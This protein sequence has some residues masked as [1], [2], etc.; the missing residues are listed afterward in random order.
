MTGANV[1]D[2]YL[3]GNL[4]GFSVGL[5]ISLLLLVLTLRAARLPGTPVA[6]IVLAGCSILWNAGGLAY[7]IQNPRMSMDGPDSASIAI[8][9]QFTGAGVWP[10]RAGSPAV[11]KT[12]ATSPRSDGNASAGGT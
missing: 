7:V 9:I 6:N 1:I 2:S 4:I 3:A 11:F 5:V 12:G 10:E 8:A